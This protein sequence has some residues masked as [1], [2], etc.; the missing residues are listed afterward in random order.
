MSQKIKNKI[1]VATETIT[2]KLEDDDMPID[3]PDLDFDP[4]TGEILDQHDEIEV[5][6]QQAVEIDKD[7]NSPIPKNI[8][9]KAK[10]IEE[11]IVKHNMQ[12]WRERWLN[13]RNLSSFEEFTLIALEWC[14]EQIY[15]HV[16]KQLEPEK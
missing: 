8:R 10:L 16:N 9:D 2:A 7:P 5:Y 13:S 15:K 12:Q 6:E 3:D 11:L 1:G 4:E 14:Q